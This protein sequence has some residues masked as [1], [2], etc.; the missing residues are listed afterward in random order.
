MAEGAV[1]RKP[2]TVV[3]LAE[4]PEFH[5]AQYNVGRIH[6]PLEDPSM[7]EFVSALEP[8]NAIAESSPGFVWRLQ[9]EDGES[10][11]YVELPGND[12]PLLIIN[13]S[14]WEDVDSLKHFISRSGHSAYLRRRREWFRRADE[15]T[16]VAWWI[17]AGSV[18]TVSEAHDRLVHLREHGPT[19][20]AFT[21]AEPWPRPEL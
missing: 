12:D 18:P 19:E 14:I 10:S 9:G 2:G 13:Y 15:E 11:S 8:I 17:P 5:L 6:Q 4:V 16:S 21:L 7:T 20:K 3:S 1:H